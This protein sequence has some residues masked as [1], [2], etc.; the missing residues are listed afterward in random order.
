MGVVAREYNPTLT[1]AEEHDLFNLLDVD[2]NKHVETSDLSEFFH[3]ANVDG[4]KGNSLL[5]NKIS[6][7]LILC[8]HTLILFIK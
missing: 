6:E 7:N 2:Q 1:Q 3:A 5:V 8:K 4:K